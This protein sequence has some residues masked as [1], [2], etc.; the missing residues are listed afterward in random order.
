MNSYA[1]TETE[2]MNLATMLVGTLSSLG[3]SE[4]QILGLSAAMS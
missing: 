3:V 1:T 2:I 4:S